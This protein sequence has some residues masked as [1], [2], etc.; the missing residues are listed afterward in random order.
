ALLECLDL[1]LK[2]RPAAVMLQKARTFV[3][4][5]SPVFSVPIGGVAGRSSIGQLTQ[6]QTDRLSLFSGF[7]RFS[8]VLSFWWVGHW[9]RQ[10]LSQTDLRTRGVRLLKQLNHLKFEYRSHPRRIP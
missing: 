8:A 10:N 7:S 9:R 5:R 2:P 6:P 4:A 1:G 3:K